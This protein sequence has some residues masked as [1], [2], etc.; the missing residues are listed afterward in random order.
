M[1][2]TDNKEKALK[3]KHLSTTA[4]I[5]HHGEYDHDQV[6]WNDRLPN[7]ND[8]DLVLPNEKLEFIISKKR[9]N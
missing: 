8:K 9:K 2:I 1:I 5:E 3:A 7:I 6:G 4:K